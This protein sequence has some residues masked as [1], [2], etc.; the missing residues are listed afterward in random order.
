MNKDLNFKEIGVRIQKYRMKKGMTQEKLAEYID[1]SQKYVSRI[2][3]GYNRLSL[4]TTAAIARALNIT[5]DSLIADYDNSNDESTLHEI[6]NDIRGMSPKQ[7][8]LL[9]DII[10]ILKKSDI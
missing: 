9:R 10:E 8:A 1:T 3:C 5:L 7:L 6:L 4:D 2:E